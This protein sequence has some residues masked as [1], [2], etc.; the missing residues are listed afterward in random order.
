MRSIASLTGLRGVA[1]LWVLLYHVARFAPQ[2]GAPW[3]SELGLLQV[4]WVGVDLF[5]VLSGFIL[6][7]VHAAEFV[8]PSGPAVR[9]FAILRLAR[10]YPVSLVVLGLIVLLVCADP[11]FVAW[12]RAR[13]PDN[14]SLAA[15]VRTACLATRWFGSPG[16][17][18]NQPVWSLSVELVAY[19]AFPGLAWMLAKRSAGTAILV[20]AA[21]LGILAVF[22]MAA[23][24][25]G[26]NT[27]DQ[28]SALMRMSCCF[29]AGAAACQARIVL[30]DQA[31]RFARVGALAVLGAIILA[32]QSPTG[33]LWTPALFTALILA[34]SFQTG[35]VD[36]WLSSAPVVLLG[37]ISFPLYLA[38][39]TP[40]LWMASHR[41]GRMGGMAATGLLAA[42]I[43]FCLTAAWVLHRWVEQPVH[44][45]ARQASEPLQP[46]VSALNRT[47]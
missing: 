34:L 31:A 45:W 40:L 36:R 5:F 33:L 4:G 22:Q 8:Q 28:V 20:A 17:D 3:V 26:K 15:L 39:L 27:I 35:E 43:A 16:G 7:W 10:V 29:T 37:K 44:R 13:N 38:H 24:I 46:G 30:A 11:G 25:A 21:S 42:Y 32:L 41:A 18:W 23:G 12:S 47:A 2:V 1:A 19:A 14:F 9:R 6:M